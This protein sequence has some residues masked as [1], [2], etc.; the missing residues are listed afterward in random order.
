[1]V[2]CLTTIAF[3]TTT[4][5]PPPLI[6][7]GFNLDLNA[8]NFGIKVEKIFENIKKCIVKGE[9]NKIVEYM[10]DIKHEVEQYTGKKIDIDKQI[11][12]VQR[13]AK[14][15]GRNI[16]DR[17]I[18]QIKKDFHREDKK[19]KHRALWFVQCAE[20]DIPYSTMDAD[21]HFDINYVMAKSA[22]GGDKDIDVP[23]PIMVGVTVTLCGLFLVFVPLPGC[24]T[25]G[26]WLINT[27]ISILGGDAIQRWDAY[28]RDSKG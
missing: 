15:K 24:H 21:M 11:D 14:A 1:M 22:K 13:E 18:Q 6:A 10:F 5:I 9:T 16:D 2:S 17:Y 28:D 20:A 8:I 12:Q 3:T 7:A 19:H 23:I 26:V 4:L 25:A 27:G